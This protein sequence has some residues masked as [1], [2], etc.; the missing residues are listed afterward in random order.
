MICEKLGSYR[1]FDSEEGSAIGDTYSNVKCL[2]E[3]CL[4]ICDS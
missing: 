1:I 3:W 2:W 4:C